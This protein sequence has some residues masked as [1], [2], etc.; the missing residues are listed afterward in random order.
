MGFS[1]YRKR[2]CT[3]RVVEADR[4]GFSVVLESGPSSDSSECRNCGLCRTQGEVMKYFKT[5]KGAD[6]SQGDEITFSYTLVNEA[7]AAL[8]LLGIPV[9][10]LIL[11][12]LLRG[13]FSGE[14]AD[15]PVT[16]LLSLISAGAGVIPAVLLE[17]KV[18]NKTEV[19]IE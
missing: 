7:A 11:T 12:V 19:E 17:K 18:Q 6:L 5:D 1:V 15:D 13:Y 10:C 14:G 8:I 2:R 4:R 3:G 16:V 9:M